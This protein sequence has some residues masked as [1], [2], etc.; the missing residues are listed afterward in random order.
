VCTYNILAKSKKKKFKGKSKNTDVNNKYKEFLEDLQKREELFR[1]N[2]R[3]ERQ[4]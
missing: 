1:D 2:L 3:A 4:L